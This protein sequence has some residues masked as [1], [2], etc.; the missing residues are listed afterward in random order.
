VRR[1][2]TQK[3]DLARIEFVAE[4]GPRMEVEVMDNSM[5]PIDGA[6][7]SR[8]RKEWKATE[9]VAQ[10]QVG[11]DARFL[12]PLLHDSPVLDVWRTASSFDIIVS[13][14]W[15]TNFAGWY[16]DRVANGKNRANLILPVRLSF[17]EVNYLRAY[18]PDWDDRGRLFPTNIDKVLPHIQEFLWT[19]I[20]SVSANHIQMAIY[21][22]CYDRNKRDYECVLLFIEARKLRIR[23]R[24]RKAW[25]RIFGDD[26]LQVFDRG[27]AI[28]LKDPVSIV[29]STEMES[30]LDE[31]GIPESQIPSPRRRKYK[32]R[33]R[34]R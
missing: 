19:Q 17:S 21:V 12:G 14:D 31:M 4:L 20:I 22:S 1:D 24:R 8:L 28:W 23:D 10:I 25:R 29:R 26:G 5:A 2:I 7:Y 33:F 9:A 18:S 16:Y 6:E 15:A 11:E 3:V 13:E 30:L 34:R 32:S 27:D